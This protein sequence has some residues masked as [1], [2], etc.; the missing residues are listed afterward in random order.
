MKHTPAFCDNIT[1]RSFLRV[2]AASA[3]GAS[4]SL[5][6]LLRAESLAGKLGNARGD[7][8]LIFVFLRGGL[9]TIDTFD[10]KPDAP[11]TIRGVFQPR[12]TNVPGIHICD[13]LPRIAGVMDKFSLIR[14][15]THSNAGHGP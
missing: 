10:M 6:G 3:L 9:S 15:F 4:F 8:S 13:Q 2:G 5:D 7:T 1:R 14:S 11:D 12:P